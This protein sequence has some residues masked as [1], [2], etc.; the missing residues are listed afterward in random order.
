MQQVNAPSVRWEW[1]GEAWNLFTKQ[2]SVWVVMILVTCLV[3]GL[4]Y[5]PL[6]FIAIFSMVPSVS[7]DGVLLR[8]RDFFQS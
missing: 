1:I 3:V 2:W 7:E 6:Y 8:R 4:I 5:L